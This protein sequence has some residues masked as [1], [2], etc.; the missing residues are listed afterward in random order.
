MPTIKP[1]NKLVTKARKSGVKTLAGF[2]CPRL[3][4]V[5]AR[6]LR[7]LEDAFEPNSVWYGGAVAWC[8]VAGDVVTAVTGGA[9]IFSGS[10][11][12]SEPD[13]V[14]VRHRAVSWIDHLEEGVAFDV[15]RRAVLERASGFQIE[16]FASGGVRACGNGICEYSAFV[17]DSGTGEKHFDELGECSAARDV[18]TSAGRTKGGISFPVSVDFVV[19]HCGGMGTRAERESGQ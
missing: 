1:L 10:A 9:G 8:V 3:F 7:A 19:G 15:D 13:C 17:I 12:D 18:W 5:C 2:V 14:R 6:N 4:N 11:C 16:H